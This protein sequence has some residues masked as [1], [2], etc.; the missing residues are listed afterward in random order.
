[1]LPPD[2]ALASADAAAGYPSG[3]AAW[4]PSRAYPE[5][6]EVPVSGIENVVFDL[7]REALSL[8]GLDAGRFGTREWNPIGALVAPGGRIVIKP[9]WV[10]HYNQSGHPLDSVITHPSVIRALI[11]Y[12]LLARPSS[13]VVGDAP[14]QGCNL[15]E[16][17]THAGFD[18]LMAHYDGRGI[19]IVWSDFRRTIRTND[20]IATTER[21]VRD[22]ADYV[23]FDIGASS[24]LEPVTSDDE[25]RFRVTMYDERELARSHRRGVHRYLIARDILDADLVINAPKLKTHKKAGITGTLKNTIGMNG[26]KEFLPHHRKGSTVTGG[27]CYPEKSIL[28]AFAE[29]CLDG[30]NKTSGLRETSLRTAARASLAVAK[31]SGTHPQVEGGWAGNDTIWRTCLDLN[32]ILLYGTPDGQLHETVK[33]QVFHVTDAFIAGEGE[34]PLAPVPRAAGWI[35][36]SRSAAAADFVHAFL[37]GFSAG[38]IRLVSE[39]FGRFAYPLCAGPADAVT[40]VTRNG[41]QQQPWP[42]CFQSAFRRPHGWTRDVTASLGRER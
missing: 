30:A 23:L 9:N 11:D 37:M 26:N 32:R 41:R 2:V 34:G 25:E 5:F 8:T 22:T 36:A 27:D 31:A 18:R 3:D 21:N 33:R 13:L 12:A 15:E 1:M 4:G 39:A 38:E 10:L 42:E 35:T 6:P 28:K 16:L 17:W 24:L 19:P 20:W 7:V 29:E 40:I 14:I